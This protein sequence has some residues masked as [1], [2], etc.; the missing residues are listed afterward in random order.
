MNSR[1]RI[2]A[3]LIVLACFILMV[4]TSV[5]ASERRES[6]HHFEGGYAP[7]EGREEGMGGATGQIAAWLLGIANFPA[8]LSIFLEAFRKVM[9]QNSNLKE[10]IGQFNQQQKRY[11][12]QLHYW[13]NPIAIIAAIIHFWSAKCETTAMPEIGLGAMILIS[14][15]GILVAF[16]WSPI[17]M[18]KIIFRFHTSSIS[19]LAII[20]ILL[21]GHSMV[22]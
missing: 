6:G 21:I 8:A 15:L 9:S 19:L 20:T 3:V 16:K 14:I 13:L 2:I 7:A 17:S 4:M 18:R 10:A 11:L 5:Y 22:D 1:P 12:M